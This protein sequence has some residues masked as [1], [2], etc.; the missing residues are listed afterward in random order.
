VHGSSCCYSFLNWF[1]YSIYNSKSVLDARI[2]G[3]VSS[4]AGDGSDSDGSDDSDS[5]VSDGSETTEVLCKKWKKDMVYIKSLKSGSTVMDAIRV[6]H[7]TGP[8]DFFCWH[9][10][11]Q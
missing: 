5:T 10:S 7:E 2:R 1:Y 11:A 3:G 6:P 4:N 9:P 8:G